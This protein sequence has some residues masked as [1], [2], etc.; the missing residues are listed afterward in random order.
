MLRWGLGLGTA[1]V[2]GGG[3]VAFEWL[4]GR[5]VR[6]RVE[7]DQEAWANPFTQRVAW[8]CFSGHPDA[9]IGVDMLFQSSPSRPAWLLGACLSM[10][11]GE[12]S[13]V[14]RQL[15]I[16]KMREAPEARLLRALA[17]R[18]PHATDWRH[19]FLETWTALGR[20]DFR[21]STLLPQPLEWNLV[22]GDTAPAWK[23]A[24]EAQ[25]F[26][27]AVLAPT[28]AEPGPQWMLAQVRASSSVPL[29]MALHEQLHGLDEANMPLRQLLLPRVE[30]RLGQL[31][32]SFPQSLQLALVSFLAGSPLEAPFERRDLE[33][34]D[35]LVE[36]TEWKQPSTERFFLE[37]RSLFDG[38]LLAPG[39]HAGLVASMSQGVFLGTRLMYRAKA[40][41]AHLTEDEQ[42]WMGRLLWEV[43]TR[44]CGQRSDR[45][46]DMGLRLQMFGSELT[47]HV[48]T[49]EDCI[50]RW[51]ELGRWED[52]VKQAAYHRWPLASLQE[53]S[54]E[55][56]ARN[57]HVWMQAFAGQGALP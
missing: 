8:A 48:P 24:T 28:L 33:A 9:R 42:R 54:Q 2:G 10:E 19:A 37:L 21:K 52:A 35:K 56:R 20:P 40:S 7:A 34:L 41:K 46:L 44:L 38:L 27:L 13:E 26:P 12:W 36:L 57:E 49:R 4:G 16:P 5:Q 3:W 29:L 18:R 51:G 39:H 17:E 31:T 47:Q 45:E 25:R 32:G 1:A 55:P 14:R 6:A 50:A 11:K 23:I 43:G 22:L 53:E 30:E 15:D